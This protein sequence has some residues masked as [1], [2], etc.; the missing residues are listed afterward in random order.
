MAF[1]GYL[2]KLGG[3]S[4]T[5][6]PLNMVKAESY[7]ATPNQRMESEAKRDTTGVLHRTTVSHTATKI[8]INTIP[9]TNSEWKTFFK[10]ITDAFTVA[11]ERKLT[12]YYY[13]NDTDDYKS[14]TF[15]MPDIQYPILRVD[16]EKNVIHYDSIR[17]AFIEY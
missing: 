4:G 12:L 17:L 14:G 10:K 2:I 15:Y 3:S 1:S 11:A 8:E 16:N 7:S 9:M 13:D 6:L 5:E